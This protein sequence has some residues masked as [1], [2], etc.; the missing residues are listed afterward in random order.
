[1]S[2]ENHNLLIHI[3]YHKCASTWLQKKVFSDESTFKL[4]SKSGS[5]EELAKALFMDAYGCLLNS[6]DMN[7]ASIEQKFSEIQD[8]AESQNKALVI[9]DERLSGNPHAGGFD[10]SIIAKRIAVN[11]PE[12]KILI[13]I[14]EQKSWILSNYFQYLSVGGSFG[15]KKYLFTKYDGKISFFSPNHI[16]YHYLIEHYIELFGSE[17]V[18]I[19]PY[20]L[21][22]EDADLFTNQ[23]C[24]LCSKPNINSSIDYSSRRNVTKNLFVNHYLRFF[25]PFI[26]KSSVN[27]YS[28]LYSRPTSILLKLLRRGLYFLT[29]KLLDVWLMNR[30][31]R[32]IERWAGNRYVYSNSLTQ[33]YVDMDLKIYGYKIDERHE[34]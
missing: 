27:N 13:I 8:I 19:L 17:N 28:S 16:K 34:R 11:F 1:M 22:Q 5:K 31:K 7:Q 24:S 2:G 29:P 6:F 18:L 21:L 25:N 14:R 4:V 15:I 10:A 23:I 9:S 3:G 26:I 32:T 12:A 30:M 33:Q 20:E